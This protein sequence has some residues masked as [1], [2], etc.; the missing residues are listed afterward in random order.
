MLGHERKISYENFLLFVDIERLV[1]EFDAGTD[2]SF[3]RQLVLLCVM[4]IVF[5]LGKLEAG[6]LEFKLFF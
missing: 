6:E 4:F 5:G 3:K 2:R 1:F